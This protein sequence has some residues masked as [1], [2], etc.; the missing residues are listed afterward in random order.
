MLR[1][2]T[3][4][5]LAALPGEAVAGTKDGLRDV[6]DFIRAHRHDRLED[7]RVPILGST[8]LGVV[9]H[10]VSLVDDTLNLAEE[11]VRSV[12]PPHLRENAGLRGFGHYLVVEGIA[13]LAAER[14][15]RRDMYAAAKRSAAFFG[16]HDA[17]LREAVFASALVRVRGLS[18]AGSRNFRSRS[19]VA[20]LAA[21]MLMEILSADRSATHS[22]GQELNASVR[23]YA[24]AVLAAALASLN[25]QIVGEID[26]TEVGLFAVEARAER[27]ASALSGENPREALTQVFEAL[28]SHLP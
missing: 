1:P 8:L 26:L 2:V 15:F 21:A 3:G 19:E 6:R 5:R 14:D 24:P 7:R 27:I 9:A 25:P 12:R 23:L 16:L 20:P 17:P 4:E 11:T 28:L 13:R 10:A 18:H 22:S